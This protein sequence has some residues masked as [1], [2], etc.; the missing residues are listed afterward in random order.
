MSDDVQ[1]YYDDGLEFHS[2]FNL[3]FDPVALETFKWLVAGHLLYLIGLAV[4]LLT[5]WEMGNVWITLLFGLPMLWVGRRKPE[6]ARIFV[7]VVAFTALHYLAVRLAVRN[8]SGEPSLTPGLIGGAVG[9]VGSLA[10]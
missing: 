6:W 3:G 4:A 5:H 7:F 1:D 9:A 10:L 8:S 2:P